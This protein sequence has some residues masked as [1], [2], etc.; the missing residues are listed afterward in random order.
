M[1]M[2]INKGEALHVQLNRDFQGDTA[3]SE[4]LIYGPKLYIPSI[5]ETVLQIEKPHIVKKD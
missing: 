1:L 5:E 2:R 4:H 3:G